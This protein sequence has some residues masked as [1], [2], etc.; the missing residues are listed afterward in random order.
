M[1]TFRAYQLAR[2]FH[3]EIAPLQLKRPMG[4][5][6]RRAASG[7]ALNLAEG[8]GR[9][10]L[11]DQRRFFVIALGSI[12]ECQAVFDLAGDAVSAAQRDL[13]DH[14]AASVWR[15]LHPRGR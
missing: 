1:Q 7:A 9:Q 10:S 13:L 15:L 3:A 8:Y 6:L 11:S 12:R 5:H 14:L 4:S 2:R